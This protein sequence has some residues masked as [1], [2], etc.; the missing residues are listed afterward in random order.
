[1]P[2]IIS[3]KDTATLDELSTALNEIEDTN[4][5]VLRLSPLELGGDR[6]NRVVTQTSMG[7]SD[8]PPLFIKEVPEG[9]RSSD[10]E[11]ATTAQGKAQAREA[12]LTFATDLLINNDALC[13]AE[14][15]LGADTKEILLLREP[16]PGAEP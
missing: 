11:K 14:V 15:A 6:I 7:A 2:D 1:M 5:E 3:L 4:H 13:Y 8:L 12:F 9:A 16:P 10:I